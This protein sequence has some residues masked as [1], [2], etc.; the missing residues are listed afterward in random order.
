MSAVLQ[1]GFVLA[2]AHDSQEP[3]DAARSSAEGVA[4]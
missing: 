2:R 3:I 4:K 1:G